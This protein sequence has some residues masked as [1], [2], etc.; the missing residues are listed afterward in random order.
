MAEAPPKGRGLRGWH[1]GGRAERTASL[2]HGV[3][4]P[5]PRAWPWLDPSGLLLTTEPAR[6]PPADASGD[7]LG[8]LAGHATWAGVSCLGHDE[9]AAKA[10]VRLSGLR[11][12]CLPLL[13]PAMWTWVRPDW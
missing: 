3:G 6:Q 7:V 13:G 4:W 8:V 9:A 12:G 5:A 2:L 1:Q 10:R 11:A